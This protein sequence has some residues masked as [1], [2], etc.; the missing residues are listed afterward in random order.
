MSEK[1]GPISFSSENDEVFLGMSYSNSREYSEALAAEI[2]TEVKAII[3]NAYA[4]CEKVLTDNMTQLHN[5][6]KALFEKEK[7][8]GEEFVAIFEQ[9]ETSSASEEV[10]NEDISEE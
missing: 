1:L 8:S 2:D 9:K 4:R 7:L 3:D 10:T 6:A 5:V